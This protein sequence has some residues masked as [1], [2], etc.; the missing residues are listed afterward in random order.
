VLDEADTYLVVAADKGTARLSDTA[1]AIAREYGFWLDDAFASGGST[2]Y[3]HKALG[4]TA[5]GAWEAVRRHFRELGLDPERDPI[6]AVGVGDM[7]GDVFGNGMLLSRSL[8]LL[9]AYDHRHVFLDP[10]PDV[11]RA[12][13]ERARLFALPASSWDEYDR[14][15][16]SPGGGVWPRSAKS[17]PLA[18]EVR[19]ALGVEAEALAPTELIRAILR[20]PVDLL[21]N[22]GIGTVVKA[23]TETDADAQDRASDPIRVDADQL[24]CRVVAEGGNLGLTRRARVEYAA[25]GGRVNADFIDNSAG[26]NCSDHEV[27]LKILLDLAVRRG[28]L[29]REARN[30]LLRDVTEDVVAHVLYDSFLQAQVLS[31]EVRESAGRMYAYE[32]LMVSL[33]ADGRLDRAAEALP[34]TQAMAE[35]HRAGRGM[36]RPELALLLAYAKRDVAR[37]LLAS[38]LLDDPWLARDLEAYFPA[39]VVARFRHLLE[40][41]PLRRR[42]LATISANLVL[43]AL[44]PTFVSHLVIERGAQPAEVV[45]AYRIAREVTGAGPRWE[46]I[47]ALDGVAAD[48]Q[49]RLMAGADRLVEAVTRWYLAWAPG[50]GLGEAVARGRAGWTAFADVVAGLASEEWDAAAREL[51]AQGVPP[52]LAAEHVRKRALESGPDVVDVAAALGRDVPEVAQAFFL[53]RD[54]LGMDRLERELE[55]LRTDTRTGRWALQAMRED[56][57]RARRE[58]AERALAERP[59]VPVQE[60]VEAF[61]AARDASCR[62][63]GAFLRS[64]SLDGTGDLTALGL[65]V[66]HLGG[67]AEA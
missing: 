26:V 33:E 30:A 9:A 1:N 42:L 12:Y 18:P 36:E 49:V 29:D 6:S 11:E 47:E 13:A 15:H 66:R 64:L 58:L 59:D 35:R 37:A 65:A 25:R 56:L 21:W 17:V 20:A 43:N 22:G 14:R 7:S 67:I 19:A 48:V 5:R 8:R 46:A 57:L 31:Q 51:E 3:D 41:H 27:N 24:R 16:L 52:A 32:D 53:V 2:G 38:P 63:L 4:I 39:P 23:S 44:G 34:S 55:G 40:A 50:A 60:A 10:D 62:R 45:G 28:E 54:R 61:L